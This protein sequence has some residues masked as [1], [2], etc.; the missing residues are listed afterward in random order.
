MLFEAGRQ[1]RERCLEVEFDSRLSG[2]EDREV[3]SLR[4]AGPVHERD[5]HDSVS[6]S[7]CR[8]ASTWITHQYDRLAPSCQLRNDWQSKRASCLRAPFRTWE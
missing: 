2:S 7:I 8:K 6:R 1:G 4:Q 3:A 5:V